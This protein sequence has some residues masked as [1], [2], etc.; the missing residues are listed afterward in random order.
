MRNALV[1]PI[2]SAWSANQDPSGLKFLDA[3]R[4]ES[5]QLAQNLVV[6]F[7]EGRRFEFQMPRQVQKSQREAGQL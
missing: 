2:F 4:G 7:A 1:E 3:F 5:D 6:V